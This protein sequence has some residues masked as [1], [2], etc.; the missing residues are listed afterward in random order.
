MYWEPSGGSRARR[1][2]EK[3]GVRREM[4]DTSEEEEE[5]ELR[6]RAVREASSVSVRSTL[7]PD[8][9]LRFVSRLRV[10]EGE[11]RKGKGGWCCCV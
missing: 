2:V 6:P 9:P 7:A 10:A 8:E 5:E 11:E 4:G 1:G 3:G